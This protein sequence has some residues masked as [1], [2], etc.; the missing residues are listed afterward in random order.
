[1]PQPCSKENKNKKCFEV[2]AFIF[3]DVVRAEYR[4]LIPMIKCLIID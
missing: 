2:D 4:N 3:K 1:V